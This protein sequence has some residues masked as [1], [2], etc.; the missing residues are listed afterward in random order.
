MMFFKTGLRDSSLIRKLTMKNPRVL[1]HMFSITNKYALAEEVA[2]DTREQKKELSHPDQ[3]SA[4][5]GHNKKRKP[6]HSVNAIQQPHRHKEYR[7]RPGEFE[8]FL[9]CICIFH[10]RESTR[11]ET[12]TDSKV[13]Q[14]RFSRQASWPIMRGSLRIPRATSPRCARSS[15]I[16]LVTLTHMSPRESKNS[17]PGRSWQSVPPPPSTLDGQWSPLPSTVVTNRTLCQTGAV[18]SGSLPHHKRCQA[19][20]STS[21]WRQ[22]PQLPFSED[23]QSNGVV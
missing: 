11:P 23:F 14:M 5:K 22:L 13:L 18:S 3:P 15:T 12:M 16:F 2:L 8:G 21:G 17:Q 6:D 7:P 4:S 20:Q 19:Q 10:P 9:D 1:E